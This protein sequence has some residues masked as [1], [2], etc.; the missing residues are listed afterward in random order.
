LQV[1]T[2]HAQF[3]FIR[4]SVNRADG[5]SPMLQIGYL[6]PLYALRQMSSGEILR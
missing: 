2:L 3:A 5:S 1:R 6:D 4:L